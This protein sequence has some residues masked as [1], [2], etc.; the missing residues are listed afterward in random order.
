MVTTSATSL[1]ATC[2]YVCKTPA[3]K[4]AVQAA[5]IARVVCKGTDAKTGS[6][7]LANG[8]L[9]VERATGE[10]RAGGSVTE[11][12]LK[13]A[14]EGRVETGK[15]IADEAYEADGSRKL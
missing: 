4:A 10:A 12:S 1:C 8:A 13:L 2:E 3:G 6:L 15:L 14:S 5:H 7:S 11:Y 9:T